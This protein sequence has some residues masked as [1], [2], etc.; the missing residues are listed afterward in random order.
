MKRRKAIA[1]L[2]LISLVVLSALGGS[3]LLDFPSGL[4]NLAFAQIALTPT[5]IPS[6]SGGGLSIEDLEPFVGKINPP[7][8]P[9][10]DSGLNRLI[11]KVEGGQF[12]ATVAAAESPLSLEESVAV[13]L[14]IADDQVGNVR[15]FL[16]AN[17]A[18]V[19]NIGIDY[20][21]A[22][23]PVSLLPQASQ[24][25]GVIS[26]SS[27][28]PAQ[29]AQTTVVDGAVTAHG[30]LAWHSAGYRGQNIKIGIIDTGFESIRRLGTNE[31]PSSVRQRCYTSVGIF[32]ANL[33]DCESGGDHGTASTESAFDIAPDADYYISNPISQGDLQQSVRWM[34]SQGVDVIN[35]SVSNLW[36]GPG[37]GMTPFSWGTLRSVDIAIRSGASW[38]NAAG[39]GARE[40]WYG[41]FTDL[42]GDGL[43]NFEGV[44][45]CVCLIK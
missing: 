22:Y 5:P 17:G 32:T 9:G 21:D 12:T 34:I 4:H 42:D 20:I 33:A 8:Y 44:D 2:T 35:Y 18:S 16:S 13:T 15:D 3:K 10:M 25:E 23:V 14:Q 1:V 43:H 24:Q 30:A 38:T 29:L 28:V 27:I 41:R 31:L 6:H 40:T 26:I 39:N 11:A 36:E 45:D 19:R 37:D 7:Q